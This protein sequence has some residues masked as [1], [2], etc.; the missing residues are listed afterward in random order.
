[1][2][3][4]ELDRMNE[5]KKGRPYS[6]PDSFILVIGYMRSYFHLPYRQTEGIIKATGKSLPRHPSY[7]HICKRINNLKVD[8]NSGIM[9]C[10]GDGDDHLI[11]AIDSTGIKVTNRGQWMSDKW[12]VGNKRKRGYLKIHVAVNTK[13]REILA[14]EVTDEKVHDSRIMKRL[15]KHVL[16]NHDKENGK[17]K[18]VLS[19][20]AY[21]SNENF[22]FLDDRRIKPAIKVK[23]NSIIS[24]GSNKTRNREVSHQTRDFLKWKK[25]KRYGQRWI[26]E[27]AF[28]SIKRMFG[29]HAS[30]SSFQNMAKEMV[31]KVSLYNLFTRLA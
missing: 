5:S 24:S 11:I 1:M 19:D 17:I 29:E 21:D 14:L 27:T 25:K 8:I 23:R 2:W 20:G 22:K 28:S 4:S 7:G 31:M 12:G 30:A 9:T 13:T 15:V 3:D 16:D 6:F 26:A 10:D 18:S